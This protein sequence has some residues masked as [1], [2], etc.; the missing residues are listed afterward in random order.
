MSTSAELLAELASLTGMTPAEWQ[1]FLSLPPEAQA[2]TA[3]TY[4]DLSW[5][6]SPDTFGKVLAVLGLLGTIAADVSGVA[7]AVS[8][9][10][11]LR[12]L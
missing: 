6:T 4:R 10:S 9:V 1:D 11:A 3:Q 2:I 12:A 5:A 8:A 7:G